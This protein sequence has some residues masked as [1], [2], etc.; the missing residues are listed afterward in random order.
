MA[1]SGGTATQSGIHYQNSIAALYLGRLIDSRQ[2][3]ASERVVEV[4]VEAPDH[5]DDIVV[6]HADG[7]RSFIQAKGAL[8]TTSDAWR[9]LWSDFAEQAHECND[10]Q[11][12]LILAVGTFSVEIDHLRELCDRAKGRKRRPFS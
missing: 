5:V 4:R 10:A 8:S 2:R 6:R 1:E 11:F 9:K 12:H 7:G 3:I